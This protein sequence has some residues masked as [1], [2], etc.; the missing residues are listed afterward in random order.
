MKV[1]TNDLLDLVLNGEKPQLPVA[2]PIPSGE[3]QNPM[4]SGSPGALSGKTVAIPIPSGEGQN[5]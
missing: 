3:G 4:M 2:I 5:G 1:R